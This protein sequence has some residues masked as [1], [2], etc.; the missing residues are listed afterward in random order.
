MPLI[1]F[2]LRCFQKHKE[3]DVI[4]A[5][6]GIGG[7]NDVVIIAFDRPLR[8]RGGKRRGSGLGPGLLVRVHA[9]SR[10]LDGAGFA[11]PKYAADCDTNN[12]LK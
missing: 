12:E 5:N 10:R 8:N 1:A 2:A 9:S 7:V 11:P 4:L 3:R 6:R